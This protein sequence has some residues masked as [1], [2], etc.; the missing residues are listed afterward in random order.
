MTVRRSM[1]SLLT[2][3]VWAIGHQIF[4]KFLDTYFTRHAIYHALSGVLDF[5]DTYAKQSATP[6]DDALIAHLRDIIKPLDIGPDPADVGPT[7]RVPGNGATEQEY[8]YPMG[9]G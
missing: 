8:R 2:A 5:L 6:I 9:S 1:S 7:P 3:L 4:A